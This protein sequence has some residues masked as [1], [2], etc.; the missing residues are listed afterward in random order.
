MNV[1]SYTSLPRC[2]LKDNVIVVQSG[3]I[4][5]VPSLPSLS[6]TRVGYALVVALMLAHVWSDRILRACLALDSG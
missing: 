2:T 3:K 6:L 4:Y 1:L 5:L